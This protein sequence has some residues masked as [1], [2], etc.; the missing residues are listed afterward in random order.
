MCSNNNTWWKA[1]GNELGIINNGI[2]NGVRGTDTI[3]I[4]KKGEVLRGC[5]VI[6]AKFSCD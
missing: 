6:Y 2:E 5:T 1:V 3:E 4:I